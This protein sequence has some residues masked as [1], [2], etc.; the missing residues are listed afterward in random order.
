MACANSYDDPIH[1]PKAISDFFLH[2]AHTTLAPGSRLRAPSY[3]T[4]FGL[5]APSSRLQTPGFELQAPS[6][7][8][9]V[10]REKQGSE[11]AELQFEFWL[12]K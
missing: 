5:Q 6:S 4:G 8:H 1:G 10:L 7:K 2:Y 3:T 11:N 12:Y 9:N